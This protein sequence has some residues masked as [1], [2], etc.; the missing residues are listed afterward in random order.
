MSVRVFGG[1]GEG[2]A[3]FY[4]EENIFQPTLE[5]IHTFLPYESPQEVPYKK[6][7]Y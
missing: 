2:V 3:V 4:G 6:A 5:I 7:I 1:V